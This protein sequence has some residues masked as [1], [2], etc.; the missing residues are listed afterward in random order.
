MSALAG[1]L[2]GPGPV[3]D[4]LRHALLMLANGRGDPPLR[5]CLAV[6]TAIELGST[7]PQASKAVRLIFNR[8]ELLLVSLVEEGQR[9]GEIDTGRDPAQVAGTLLIA[10]L[11]LQVLGR[12]SDSPA[13]SR[14]IIESVIATL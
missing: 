7:D 3:K 1:L 2:Q 12:A 11:G 8:I 9:R 5:G 13:R 6:N 14:R 10:V 4:R